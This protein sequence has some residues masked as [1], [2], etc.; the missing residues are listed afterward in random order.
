MTLPTATPQRP[1]RATQA[2][3]SPTEGRP[4]THRV[5]R[6][7]GPALAVLVAGLAVGRF[8]TADTAEPPP[9][10]SAADATQAELS[11]LRADTEQRPGSVDAWVAYGAAATRQAA[12]TGDPA[13]YAVAGSALASAKAIEPER[14]DVLTARAALALAVH[15]FAGALP[16]ARQ[17][18]TANPFS[19]G[20]LAALV[21]ANVENGDVTEASAALDRLLAVAP[22]VQGY[23]RLSYL[24]QLSG[25][26]AGARLAMQQAVASVGPGPERATVLSYLGDITLE[27]GRVADANAA[28]ERALADQPDLVPASLGRARTLVARG[29]LVEAAAV[30]DSVVAR[31]PQPA[32]AQLRVEIAELMGDRE[33]LD[34]AY[35]LVDANDRLQQAQGVTTDLEMA[36]HLADRGLATGALERAAAAYEARHTVYTADA[37][38]WALF[39]SGDPAAALPYATEATAGGTTSPA[40][41]VHAA[42]AHAAAGELTEAADL[43]RRAFASSPWLALPIRPVAFDLAA[44]L[45]LAIPEEWNP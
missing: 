22:G 25:D 31:S 16:L 21:D 14:A 18:A 9:V 30:V 42:A 43:L 8:V 5:G 38:A 39:R 41:L 44:E 13:W 32:A 6:L 28:Y 19:A 4:R 7:L 11:R 45:E 23:A 1:A 27:M 40:I 36:V 12:I 15:D 20:A 3:A 33:A 29:A 24:R 37:M 2:A 26:M 35:R 17:A 10:V 34:Q